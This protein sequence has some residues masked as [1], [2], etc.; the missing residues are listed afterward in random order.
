MANTINQRPAS[1]W[2]QWV[3]GLARYAATASKDPST[4]CGAVIVGPDH[5]VLGLGYNGFPRGI[6]DKP[7]RLANRDLKYRLVVHAE[8]NAIMN[9]QGNT[10]GMALFTTKFP[11][12]DCTKL[13]IQAGIHQ[14]VAPVSTGT[15]SEQRWAEDA[16]VSRAMLLEAGVKI[17]DLE[18]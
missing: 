8:A 16:R 11:C 3:M 13:I 9:A 5:K 7:D 15:P 14:I 6:D 12:T 10:R 18:D 17:L 4:K 1:W 2:T